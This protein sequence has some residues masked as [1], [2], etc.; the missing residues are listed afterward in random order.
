MNTNKVFKRLFEKYYI[1]P[2]ISKNLTPLPCKGMGVLKPLPLQ[3]RGLERGQSIHS[4][5]SKHPLIK[6]CKSLNPVN[7]DSDKKD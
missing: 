3:G 1:K 2:V 6:F 5:L 4:K 7:P